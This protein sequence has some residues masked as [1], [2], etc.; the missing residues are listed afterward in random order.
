MGDPFSTFVKEMIDAKA[1]SPG[2]DTAGREQL[3]SDLK[4]RLMDQIN[5]AVITA[6]PED[7]IDGF[8]ELLDRNPTDEEIQQYVT[9]SGVDAQQVTLETMLRFRELYL[10]ESAPAA[11]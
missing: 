1:W 11:E 2:I 8:N 3:E 6:I 5:R 7:K 10:G 4:Q 9:E